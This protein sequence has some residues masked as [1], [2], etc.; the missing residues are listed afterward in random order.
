MFVSDP[1][2]IGTATDNIS[3]LGLSWSRVNRLELNSEN[4]FDIFLR[5]GSIDTVLLCATCSKMAPCFNNGVCNANSFCECNFGA[6]GRLCEKDCYEV[7][8]S[9]YCPR[10]FADYVVDS[11][12]DLQ[13]YGNP[14]AL[15]CPN[16][17]NNPEALGCVD[18]FQNF[19]APGCK[20]ER[21]V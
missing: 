20:G 9:K 8:D 13:C 1:I 12:C 5:G 2:D 16:C 4:Y 15:D 7:P 14:L 18:C 6:T 21:R 19:T 3:P 10:C 17:R 11:S